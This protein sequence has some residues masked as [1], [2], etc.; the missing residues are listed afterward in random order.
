[1]FLPHPGLWLLDQ[2]RLTLSALSFQTDF[3][4]VI[5]SFF[6]FSPEISLLYLCLFAQRF[7]H[8][9]TSFHDQ[10]VG[11]DTIYLQAGYIHII[12]IDESMSRIFYHIELIVCMEKVIILIAM[13]LSAL[14]ALI[15]RS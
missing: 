1:M 15:Q 5:C 11:V 9:L 8:D 14:I 10:K 7:F 6:D 13:T 2:Q 4:G 12:H 3:P